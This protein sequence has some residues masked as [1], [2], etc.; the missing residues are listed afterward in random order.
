MQPSPVGCWRN[1]YNNI[2]RGDGSCLTRFLIKD[3]VR[4]NRMKILT[5]IS[6]YR[7][8]PVEKNNADRFA[9]AGEKRG[10][11]VKTGPYTKKELERALSWQKRIRYNQ[12]A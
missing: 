12:T 8:L 5:K 6:L 1:R 7:M 11:F 10:F 2:C 4:H 9:K 3:R